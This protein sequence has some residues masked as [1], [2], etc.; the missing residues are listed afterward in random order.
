MRLI[1]CNLKSVVRRFKLAASLHVLGLSVAF[2][3][4]TVIMIQLDYPKSAVQIVDNIKSP[5]LFRGLFQL[6]FQMKNVKSF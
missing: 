1:L 5:R 6:E 2:A 4:F 3:A